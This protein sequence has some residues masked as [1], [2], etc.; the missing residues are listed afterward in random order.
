MSSVGTKN[1]GI[2]LHIGTKAANPVGDTFV[3]V[4][5]VK[6][7]GE[8]GSEAPIIDATCLEDSAK[9][10]L[11]GIPDNGDIEITLQRVFTDAGQT[12]LKA[13]GADTDDDPYNFKITCPGV[14]AAGADVVFSFKAMVTFREK[15]GP[16]DGLM[17]ATSKLSVSGAVTQA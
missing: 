11:K 10:K 8:F 13:A 17:E 3:Q 1:Q 5:R 2:T 4:K 14:G 16:V 9:E 12:A 15:V 7:I 6:S